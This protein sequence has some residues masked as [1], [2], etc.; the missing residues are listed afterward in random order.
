MARAA[1]HREALVSTAVRLFRRQGYAATGLGQLLEES[2]APRGSLYHYFPG[3]KADIGAA[4]V[5]HAGQQVAE[6]IA[7]L[8]ARHRSAAGFAKAYVRRYARW[9]EESAFRSG[10]P[11]ATTLLER[12]PDDEAIRAAGLAAITGWIDAIAEVFRRDGTGAKRARSEAE[13]L[14]S[15]LEGALVLAR[16][17]RSTAP[18][19]NVG[20]AAAERHL[21][22]DA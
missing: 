10:C 11:I 2:G 16:V 20:R 3:G 17:T 4:A 22:P 9:M 7:D 13:A 1:I 19:L 15:G 6:M 5:E 14:V 12:A 18:I 8:A 21:A